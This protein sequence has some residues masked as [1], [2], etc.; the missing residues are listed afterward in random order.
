[1]PACGVRR[2]KINPGVLFARAQMLNKTAKYLLTKV[3]V[4][5]FTTI[6]AGQSL[7]NVILGQLPKRI[8]VN[9]VNNKTFKGN[10]NLN[11]FNFK[12]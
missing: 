11:L 4:K 9:F 1:M 7:D 2:A 10:K 12:N 5:T 8:I 6:H 3:E